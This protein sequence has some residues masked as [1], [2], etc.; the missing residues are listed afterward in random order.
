M[1]E[2]KHLFISPHSPALKDKRYSINKLS[3]SEFT[4]SITNVTFKDGGNYT[5]TQYGR[6]ITE[7]KV[8]VTVLSESNVADD[9]ITVYISF[10][11]TKDMTLTMI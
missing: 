2:M 6:H 4:V 11:A 10:E 9:R 1:K 8:E 7:K 3:E 5:C